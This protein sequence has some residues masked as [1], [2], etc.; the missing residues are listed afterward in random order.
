MKGHAIMPVGTR[1]LKQRLSAI[2][3]L[4][5]TTVAMVA[6]VYVFGRTAIALTKWLL[7]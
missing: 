3:Y 2:F 1:Q 4:T 7:A 5:A 6:W